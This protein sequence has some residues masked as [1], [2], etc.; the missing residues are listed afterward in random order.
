ME[1]LQLKLRLLVKR[2]VEVLIIRLIRHIV[3]LDQENCATLLNKISRINYFLI[4][5]RF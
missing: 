4:Y 5:P 2:R 1:I 3:E